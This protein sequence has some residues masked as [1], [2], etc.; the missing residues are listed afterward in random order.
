LRS[1][2]PSLM[3]AFGAGV[4]ISDLLETEVP[5]NFMYFDGNRYD[6][7]LA[8]VGTDHALVI[9]FAAKK[10]AKQI[11]AVLQ[12]S[13]KAAND[14]VSGLYSV[15]EVKVSTSHGDKK[16]DQDQEEQPA[17]KDVN[18]PD[19]ENA[20]DGLKKQDAEQYWDEATEKPS[21]TGPIDEST[22]SYEEARKRG[23]LEDSE[24]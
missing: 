1:A 11:S 13:R 10:G 16:Q 24:S 23:L 6:F 7:Y 5:A 9:V 21:D 17:I 12:Y 8:S 22:L 18:E 19:L 2:V 14:L 15:G 3:K 20:A 4:E